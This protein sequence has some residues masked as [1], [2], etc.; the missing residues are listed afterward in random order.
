[1]RLHLVL[2]RTRPAE[3]KKP[4]VCPH[5]NRRSKHF[6]HHQVVG[7]PLR[8]TGYGLVSAHRYGCLRCKRAFRL[9]PLGSDSGA[10]LPESEK[11]RKRQIT[12]EIYCSSS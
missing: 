9:Y 4:S 6:G 1:M 12:A 8:D 10:E 11:T 3:F 7:K 5:S 2:P